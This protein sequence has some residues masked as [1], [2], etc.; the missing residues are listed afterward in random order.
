ML[1]GVCL[2]IVAEIW[3]LP[4]ALLV[5]RVHNN[6][7][8]AS[9]VHKMLSICSDSVSND[10]TSCSCS[11]LCLLLKCLTNVLLRRVAFSWLLVTT[12]FDVV[13]M[14][15]GISDSHFDG[16]KAYIDFQKSLGHLGFSEAKNSCLLRLN[17]LTTL[18]LTPLNC[19]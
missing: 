18:F 10:C 1:T 2:S 13:S 15:G 11:G 7:Y 16:F 8:T 17:K 4:L 3:S 9:S 12:A 6:S 19:W 5:S 14:S